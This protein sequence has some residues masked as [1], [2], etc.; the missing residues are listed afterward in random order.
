MTRK[1]VIKFTSGGVLGFSLLT[2]VMLFQNCAPTGA[3][4]SSSVTKTDCTSNCDDEDVYVYDPTPTPDDSSLNLNVTDESLI[5]AQGA[6]LQVGYA[7]ARTVFECSHWDAYALQ[8]VSDAVIEHWAQPAEAGLQVFH[9]GMAAR[10]AGYMGEF[11]LGGLTSYLQDP[12][13]KA[14][15]DREIARIAS[16][17][18][19]A[20][21]SAAKTEGIYKGILLCGGHSCFKDGKC[22]SHGRPLNVTKELAVGTQKLIKTSN[23]N[24]YQGT[25]APFYAAPRTVFECSHWDPEA[26]RNMP[27]ATI[28]YYAQ[29][30]SHGLLIFHAAM[31]ARRMGYTGAIGQ[32]G[33]GEFLNAVSTR[34]TEYD[35]LMKHMASTEV[36]NAIK[37]ARANGYGGILGCGNYSCFKDGLCDNLGRKK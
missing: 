32:G 27:D 30:S 18:V 9:V 34:G 16:P 21:I 2:L 23:G 17:E 26:I 33:F 20:A 14:A 25:V 4:E 24:V 36:V 37:D 1:R 19:V 11:G 31:A 15:Y 29:S 13:R 12:A 22:D 28:T 7:A 8:N 35:N 6:K 3:L 5:P 10:R